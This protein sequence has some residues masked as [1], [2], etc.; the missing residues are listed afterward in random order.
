MP[1]KSRPNK[2]AEQIGAAV[3][4]GSVDAA[5]IGCAITEREGMR[6]VEG[7]LGHE[8]N[9]YGN[10]ELESLCRLSET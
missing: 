3:R 2:N 9:L 4:V 7:S 6:Q 5:R 10:F 1:Q 8:E